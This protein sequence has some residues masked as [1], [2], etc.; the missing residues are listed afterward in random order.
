MPC[1]S[2]GRAD[3]LLA[4]GVSSKELRVPFLSASSREIVA[5]VQ[6][7]DRPVKIISPTSSPE[8]VKVLSSV[9]HLS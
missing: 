1:L 7:P 2:I 6:V 3:H 5:G 9:D 4:V 8:L